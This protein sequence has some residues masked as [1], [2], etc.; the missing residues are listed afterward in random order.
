[1]YSVLSAEKKIDSH[2]HDTS[3]KR[4]EKEHACSSGCF[5]A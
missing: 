4:V 1:M 2:E 3:L 5:S